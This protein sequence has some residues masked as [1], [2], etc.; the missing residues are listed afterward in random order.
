[1]IDF[2]SHYFDEVRHEND[3]KAEMTSRRQILTAKQ[4]KLLKSLEKSI[5]RVKVRRIKNLLDNLKKL[6]AQ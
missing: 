5:P 3:L 2:I 6:G 1:M 4:K